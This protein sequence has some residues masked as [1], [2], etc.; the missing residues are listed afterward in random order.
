PLGALLHGEPLEEGAPAGQRLHPAD[1]RE[2]REAEL[3]RRLAPGEIL[4]RDEAPLLRPVVPVRDLDG[5]G[6][7]G[8]VDRAQGPAGR[9]DPAEHGA[10]PGRR[11]SPQP[12]VLEHRACSTGRRGGRGGRWPGR[13]A[14]RK[15]PDPALL[16]VVERPVLVPCPADDLLDLVERL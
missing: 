8:T 14:G 10:Q 16:V 15:L 11:L 4:A 6:E 3:E 12:Q 5:Y 7:D 9:R 13:P 2:D 1:E